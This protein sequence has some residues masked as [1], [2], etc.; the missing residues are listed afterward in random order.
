MFDRHQGG[1]RAILVHVEF[2]TD[3]ELNADLRELHELTTTAG[4]DVVLS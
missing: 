1:E 3:T 4:A 2:T